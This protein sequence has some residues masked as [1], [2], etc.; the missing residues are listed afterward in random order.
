MRELTIV[1]S[2]VEG[3]AGPAVSLAYARQHIQA[4]TTADDNMIAIWT[5]AASGYFTD[6]TGRD[7]IFTVRDALLDAFPFP[8][9]SGR[10]ARIELPHPPL[11][12]VLSVE[13][14][15]PDGNV[16]PFDDG[17]S[18]ETRFWTYS[19]PQ[20]TYAPR[21]FVEPISGR[22]WPI[23]RDETGS[24][25]IRYRSGYTADPDQV[26]DLAR[27]ILCYLIAH[28][29]QFRGA[30]HEARKGQVLEL[31]YGVKAMIDG[32]KYSAAPT[33]VLRIRYWPWA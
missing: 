32:F 3:P 27:A 16:V 17:A 11:N 21:G 19:A 23:A 20:G 30:V 18:P 4:L 5:A 6:Q 8:G 26:P 31:P 13:Y 29:D 2:L 22:Q 10:E 12:E 14:V 15:D 1:D 33:Q 24:V 9:R 7:P 28:F 25:R